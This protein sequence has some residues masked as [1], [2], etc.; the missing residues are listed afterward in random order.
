[1]GIYREG[2][3]DW[4]GSRRNHSFPAH[5][6]TDCSHSKERKRAVGVC[7]ELI[8]ELVGD[9]FIWKPDSRQ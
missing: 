6:H 9:E 7:G 4:G 3:V 8:L 1:M 2:Q 5:P